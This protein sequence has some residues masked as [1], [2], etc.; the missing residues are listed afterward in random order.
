M[1]HA[2]AKPERRRNETPGTS[3]E[4]TRSPA[5][6]ST[7]CHLEVWP[8][9][10]NR[11][12]ADRVLSCLPERCRIEVSAGEALEGFLVDL[13]PDQQRL[14]FRP[15]G[16]T[17][18]QILPLDGIRTITLS[19]AVELS[20][21]AGAAVKPEAPRAYRLECADGAV[22]EGVSH[23]EVRT[24]DG[25]YLFAPVDSQRVKRSFVPA[26]LIRTFSRGEEAPLAAKASN[27]PALSL[28]DLELDPIAEPAAKP[29]APAAAV[30]LDAAPTDALA[31]IATEAAL[32]KALHGLRGKPMRRLGDTLVEMGLL[33]KAQVEEAL[34]VQKS[35]P[36]KPLGEV[37][38]E[39]GLV[40]SDALK[41]V[42]AHKVGIPYVDPR[43]FEYNSAL[44][45]LVPQPLCVRH[46]LVPLY[47][48]GESVVVAMANPMSGEALEALR[49][50]VQKKLVPVLA[51]WAEIKAVLSKS[52]S[53]DV[54]T[55]D[56]PQMQIGQDGKAG[57]VGPGPAKEHDGES[58]EFDLTGV[59]ELT[60]RLSTELHANA[61][62]HHE[63]S[64]SDQVRDSDSTLVKLVNKIIL[65]AL[66]SGASDIHIEPSHGKKPTRIRVRRD[67][68]LVDYA[69]VPAKFRSALVS[70]I[71]IMAN[72]DISEK[73]KPQDGKIDFSK[74]APVRLELRVA[75]VPTNNGVEVVILRL[76]AASE[77]IPLE[78]LG[79]EPG[80]YSRLAP[81]T[82]RP[83][84][85][86]LVCGPT[87]SGKTTTLHS[88]ISH[89]NTP[90]RKIWTAEDPVEITQPGLCQV[91]VNTKIGW[92]FGE[93]LRAFLRADPD[94]IMIGEMRD[95][96]T[97]RT[98]IEA[99]L[100]GHL[101]LST[102][103]TNSAPETVTRLLDLGV[104]P[105]N[106]GDALLG[107]LSQRLARKLCP[108]CRKS[109]PATPE[110]LRALAHEYCHHT[111]LDPDAI[112]SD[113]EKRYGAESRIALSYS[114]GCDKC[115]G[116]GLKGRVGL[117]EFMA[118][119]PQ[120]RALIQGKAN[121]DRIRTQAIADGMRTLKQDGIE[122]V[123]QGLTTIEQ[124]RAVCH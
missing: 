52:Q 66:E 56:V 107:V 105:Y 104:D 31:K 46:Q 48:D 11:A 116:T 18:D 72:L 106:F 3:Q 41:T 96:E 4:A 121:I 23:A 20:V 83:Y 44:R 53:P 62:G 73:R 38:V 93:A 111:A 124:V 60:S 117:H 101:V 28:L 89:I 98:A 81:L 2:H 57:K 64:E 12:Y 78:K 87:G 61:H 74:Y 70:R 77:P 84:G 113:W 35:G 112:E 54:W 1:L 86:I 39:M 95:A 68:D 94:V 51:N 10:A 122:K 76:L 114:T 120:T 8:A 15:A 67:G 50:V 37:L 16:S 47:L 14:R 115:D 110:T 21:P 29:A 19:R 49:F 6:R 119:T 108:D 92:G 88:M 25:L 100:T 65:D 90:E 97:A 80:V 26:A 71:K 109:R 59:E 69:Q 40:L 45:K 58:L 118:I 33:S 34:A 102:L 24:A 13:F 27:A 7:A 82:E 123:L 32:R 9:P 103:H 79:L 75:T 42:L 91:H 36:K 63:E 55:G 85:L 43:G 17:V 5:P 22:I 30:E 99:S